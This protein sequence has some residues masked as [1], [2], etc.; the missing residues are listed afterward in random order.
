MDPVIQVHL[1]RNI[2]PGISAECHRNYCTD[3]VHI[4]DGDILQR[5]FKNR[6][7]EIKDEDNYK[8]WTRFCSMF[9]CYDTTLPIKRYRIMRAE[10]HAAHTV[11]HWV[12]TNSCGKR[13]KWKDSMMT[14]SFKP[15]PT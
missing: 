12:K 10:T 4:C 8:G 1:E 9:S 5:R 11:M 14:L 15:E 6:R 7:T 2:R 13:T 3:T